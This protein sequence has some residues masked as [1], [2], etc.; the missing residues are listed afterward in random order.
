MIVTTTSGSSSTSSGVG[1]ETRERGK[2]GYN[3]LSIERAARRPGRNRC[4]SPRANR[5]ER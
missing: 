2:Q 1:S 4:E 5:D 3:A